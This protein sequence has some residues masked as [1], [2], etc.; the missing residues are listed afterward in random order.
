MLALDDLNSV[1]I[2]LI[3]AAGNWFNLG[4]DL[5]LGHDTL[6]D[7]KDDYHRNKDCLREMLAARLKTGPLTYSEICQSLRAPTVGRNDVAEAIEETCT[8]MNSH[9]ANLDHTIIMSTYCMYPFLGVYIHPCF[10]SVVNSGCK[11]V[12]VYM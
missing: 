7:M 1:Y 8:G 4:L 11:Y 2:N 9:E 5:G 12:W 6:N 10:N 3:K